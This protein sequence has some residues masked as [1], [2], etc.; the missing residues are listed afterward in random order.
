[1]TASP[2]LEGLPVLGMTASPQL[3]GLPVLGMTASP[4][5][6]RV[7]TAS[8]GL[9]VAGMTASPQLERV[10]VL[11]ILGSPKWGDRCMVGKAPSPSSE[12]DTTAH[13]HGSTEKLQ[14]QTKVH[15]LLRGVKKHWMD[16]QPVDLAR[17]T[18]TPKELVARL[19][20]TTF[21]AEQLW[22][23]EQRREHRSRLPEDQHD[24]GRQQ[25]A[26]RKAREQIRILLRLRVC[27]Q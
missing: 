8:G 18:Y 12:R 17:K 13:C 19:Q 16:V 15:E 9:A 21:H 11:G 20:R 10:W 4:Q 7:G 23:N 25:D 6:E 24:R 5:L 26:A 3:E 27:L 22:R 2:Q 14:R 1:M